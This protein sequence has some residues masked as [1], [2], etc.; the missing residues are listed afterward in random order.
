MV[1]YD[2]KPTKCTK[3]LHLG[4][5]VKGCR[6][7]APQR[8]VPKTAQDRAPVVEEPTVDDGFQLVGGKRKGT[9]LL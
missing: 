1:S 2:W 5:L 6:D 9:G 3:C 7:L 8:W 4:H